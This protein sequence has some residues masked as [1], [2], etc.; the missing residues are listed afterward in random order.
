MTPA[1]STASEALMRRL[2]VTLSM[3]LPLGFA[4]NSE[5]GPYALQ[6]QKHTRAPHSS[7]WFAG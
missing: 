2:L 1:F 4:T 5:G 7:W 3:A 6:A